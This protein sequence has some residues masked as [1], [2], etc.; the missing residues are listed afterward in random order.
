MN[1][2]T[3]VK[4]SKETTWHQQSRVRKGGRGS[5]KLKLFPSKVPDTKV[6]FTKTFDIA[7]EFL[8]KAV[9]FTQRTRLVFKFWISW[10]LASLA[11][12]WKS[13]IQNLHVNNARVTSSQQQEL[14]TVRVAKVVYIQSGQTKLSFFWQR[15]REYKVNK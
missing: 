3:A 7:S 15:N 13:F 12:N 9:F 11:L 10:N 5:S 4:K 1:E 14:T 6:A 8:A 2:W